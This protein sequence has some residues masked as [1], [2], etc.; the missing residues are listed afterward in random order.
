MCFYDYH[1]SLSPDEYKWPLDHFERYSE[2]D[3]V[4]DLFEIGYDDIAI[5]LLRQVDQV[6]AVDQR[7]E[8]VVGGGN[9]ESERSGDLL[10]RHWTGCHGDVVQHA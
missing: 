9:G 1:V 6:T 3:M 2:E 7:R 4:H 10:R 8:Q 5:L